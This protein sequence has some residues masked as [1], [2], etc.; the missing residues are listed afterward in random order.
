MSDPRAPVAAS[1]VVVNVRKPIPTNP[2]PSK[3]S[4]RIDG[5][6]AVPL[7]CNLA[8]LHDL[9]RVKSRKD[10]PQRWDE[11]CDSVKI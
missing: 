11:A 7:R 2:E 8:F 9:T 3:G 6:A 1:G 10:K 4:K 5:I